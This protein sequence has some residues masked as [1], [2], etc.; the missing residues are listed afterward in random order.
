MKGW[1]K[2][3]YRHSLASR[4]IH[5]S[6]KAKWKRMN[7]PEEIVKPHAKFKTEKT[8]P[9]SSRFLYE[10]GK[11]LGSK[12]DSQKGWD[13]GTL[14][15]LDN[16]EEYVVYDNY[17]EA[18][19]DAINRVAD[20]LNDNPEYFTKS[21]IENYIDEDRLKEVLESDISSTKR[22]DIED[23]SEEEQ[24]DEMIDAG[25]ID[26]DD[27]KDADGNLIELSDAKKKEL[28]DAIDTFV[29]NEVEATLED[30]MQ[31]LKDIWG[32]ERAIAEAIE[33]AGIDVDE[34]AEAA[35]REDGVGRWLATYDNDENGYTDFAGNDYW[36]Y[37]VN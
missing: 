33:L 7:I 28:S 9:F 10:F 2:E 6:F 26:E 31:Y 4:G 5:T 3:S 32:E 1:H 8:E 16:G 35:V 12:V 19:A 36:Y 29:E 34:A 13:N 27:F 30:P 15:V 18:E 25:L 24:V 11:E 37:R 14:I 21:W 20:D 17:D 22:D 23:R